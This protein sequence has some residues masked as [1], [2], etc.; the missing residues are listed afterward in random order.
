MKIKISVTQEHIGEG[1]MRNPYH[2]PIAL[3]C[4][5]TGLVIKAVKSTQIVLPEW[6]HIPLPR[7]AKRFISKFDNGKPVKPFNFV[8][9][10]PDG[11]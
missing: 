9:E 11:N 7:S 4:K 10:I 5:S 3:A 2:C 1:S 8:L 6:G